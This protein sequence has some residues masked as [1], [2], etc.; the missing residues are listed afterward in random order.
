[1]IHTKQ[2][3]EVLPF[4]SYAALVQL[5]DPLVIKDIQTATGATIEIVY[6]SEN[7][8]RFSHIITVGGADDVV[9]TACANLS[10]MFDRVMQVCIQSRLTRWPSLPLSWLTCSSSKVSYS[11][12]HNSCIHLLIHEYRSNLVARWSIQS[13]LKRTRRAQVSE[14]RKHEHCFDSTA[15]ARRRVSSHF[16]IPS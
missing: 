3:C 11:H 8:L 9:H 16:S 6:C 1:M 2:S 7:E 12:V 13:C 4:L 5:V 15:F 10:E 14:N